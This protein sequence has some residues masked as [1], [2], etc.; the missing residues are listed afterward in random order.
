MTGGWIGVDLDGT[1]AIYPHSFPAI[2][3]PISVMV[4]RVRRWLDAG[5]DVR[6]FTARVAHLPGESLKEGP[7]STA[8]FSANQQRLIEAWCQQHIG[9]ILPVTCV[10]D[11]KLVALWDDRCVQVVPNTGQTIAEYYGIPE[12]MKDLG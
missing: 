12:G 2:G 5:E 6:I 9:R 10:K 7:I 4:A 3:P 8:D 11:F 1:L